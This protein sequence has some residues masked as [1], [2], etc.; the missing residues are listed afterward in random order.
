MPAAM[1]E[2]LDTGMLTLVCAA[3][4]GEISVGAIYT[5]NDLAKTKGAKVLHDCPYCGKEHVFN[6]SDA[7]LRPV[8]RIM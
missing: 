5:K 3:T 4:R 1:A 8:P 7:V 2:E 6:F